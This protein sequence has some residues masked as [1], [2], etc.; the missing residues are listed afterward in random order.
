MVS[1]SLC[2]SVIYIYNIY[3]NIYILIYYIYIYILYILYIYLYTEIHKAKYIKNI[4]IHKELLTI[5]LYSFVC[6]ATA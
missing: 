1:S 6:V 4:K 2:I 5:L 3:S